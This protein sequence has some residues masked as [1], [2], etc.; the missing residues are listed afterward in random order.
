MYYIRKFKY[1]IVLVNISFCWLIFHLCV[2][3]LHWLLKLCLHT[4]ERL[5]M[6]TRALHFERGAIWFF[7]ITTYRT[8]WLSNFGWH[9][10]PDN[11]TLESLTEFSAKSDP[12]R[13]RE[14]L[15]IFLHYAWRP[16]ILYRKARYIACLT[17]QSR[18]QLI[19]VRSRH[20]I[21][22]QKYR[23]P[24]V[25]VTIHIEDRHNVEIKLI[26]QSSNAGVVL[27]GVQRLHSQRTEL[28][29]TS[30]DAGNV[31]LVFPTDKLQ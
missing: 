30:R 8:I 26:H 19:S 18:E 10:L 11:D 31:C 13:E 6:N 3:H 7:W 27:I 4:L 29:Q 5:F 21:N 15:D 28:W 9:P 23:L 22:R 24:A 1:K 2:K 25:M 16:H 12:G 20:M 17:P 14:T